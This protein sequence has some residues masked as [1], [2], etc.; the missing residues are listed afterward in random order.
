MSFWSHKQS[1]RECCSEMSCLKSEDILSV[2]RSLTSEVMSLD[3]CHIR[4]L[5]PHQTAW[6]CMWKNCHNSQDNHP[7][8]V[9][10]C[11]SPSASSLDLACKP[12]GVNGC[13]VSLHVSYHTSHCQVVQLETTP[14]ESGSSINSTILSPF[15]VF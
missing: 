14:S 13:S 15:T 7:Y 2:T 8:S 4:L 11:P 1:R 5:L 12:W 9:L 3:V 6:R 10:G